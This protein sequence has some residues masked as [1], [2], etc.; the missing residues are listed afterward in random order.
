MYLPDGSWVR[1]WAGR[2][3]VGPKDLQVDAPIGQPA[4]FY[5]DGS[6]VGTELQRFVT[7]NAL[8]ISSSH[9]TWHTDA[10]TP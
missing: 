6:E 9:H 4:V 1:L 3:H 10:P 7:Q 8:T 5:R 2:R